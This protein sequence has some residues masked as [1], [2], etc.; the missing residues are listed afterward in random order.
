PSGRDVA[1]QARRGRSDATAEATRRWPRSP[2]APKRL[3][4][5]PSRP[6]RT[7]L[8]TLA[9]FRPRAE[10]NGLEVALDLALQASPDHPW[11]KQHPEWF[12]QAPDGTIK[13]AENPPKRYEDIYPFD[14]ATPMAADREALWHAWLEVVLTWV[15]RGIR[16]FR[17]DNPHTKPVAFW[18]WLIAEVQAIDP[19]VIFLAEAFTSPKRMRALA[20]AG[21]SQRSTYITQS[22]STEY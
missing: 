4:T 6:A 18:R 22:A 8:E 2:A 9:H 21:F 19:G 5:F 15:E 10:A 17:V 14:F 3:R 16:I 12:R 13:Y 11:V 20:K 7:G 1:T